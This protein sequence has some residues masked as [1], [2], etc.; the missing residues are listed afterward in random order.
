MNAI[1]TGA[2]RGIG[3]AIAHM[4]GLHGYNLV[5]GSQ[6][7]AT[8]LA[9]AE[10]LQTRFPH[11]TVAAKALNLG[12]KDEARLFAEWAAGAADTVDVLVNNAGTFLPGT[13]LDSADDVMEKTMAVNF[14]SAY[15]ITKELLPK[16]IAQGSGH[17]FNMG[18]IA[19]LQAYPNGGAYSISKYALMGFSKNLR[20]ELMPHGIKVTT[21]IPGAVYTDSWA[22]F[23]APERIME[24]GDIAQMIYACSRLSPQAVVEDLI[25]RPLLGDL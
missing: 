23:V 25:M 20:H 8:L 13:I 10:E 6:S 18:S 11:I 9:T 19:G 5:L 17:I 2:S 1:I 22:P 3:K 16:L 12:N 24:A 21:V 14:Y 15:W 4:F 7:E